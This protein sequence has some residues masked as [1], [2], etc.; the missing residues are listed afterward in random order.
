MQALSHLS[1]GPLPGSGRLNLILLRFQVLFQL[2][3]VFVVDGEIVVAVLVI[4]DLEFL[5]IIVGDDHVIVVVLGAVLGEAGGHLARYCGFFLVLGVLDDHVIVFA[6]EF[7][8]L[9]LVLFFLDF[10]FVLPDDGVI[11]L[12]DLLVI[13]GDGLHGGASSLCLHLGDGGADH[14]VFGVEFGAAF[15]ADGR[16]F[17][18]VVES[19][20]AGWADLLGTELVLGHGHALLLWVDGP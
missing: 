19:R 12:L 15:R 3:F 9:F 14:L 10:V 16:A 8:G 1:Y 5:V 7:L 17:V 11:L 18:E 20:F 2:D 13:L 6:N 4:V